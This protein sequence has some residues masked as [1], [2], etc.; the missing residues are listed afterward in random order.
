MNHRQLLEKLRL[1]NE[2]KL[3]DKILDKRLVSPVNCF[4]INGLRVEVYRNDILR[5]KSDAIVCGKL[6]PVNPLGVIC[7]KYW[8]AGLAWGYTG[9]CPKGIGEPID[10]EVIIQLEKPAENNVLV[11]YIGVVN[12][13][14][15]TI[16]EQLVKT[17]NVLCHEFDCHEI[18]VL[19]PTRGDPN[20]LQSAHASEIIE[21]IIEV[22][23]N[24]NLQSVFLVDE[25]NPKPFI[26]QLKSKGIECI[27]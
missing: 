17:I 5:L 6:T 25:W 23:S 18:S 8:G 1:C 13:L 7:R 22:S 24:K 3:S 21:G 2:D 14:E 12:P 16:K 9:D 26:D 10:D 19:A 15:R 11:K 27:A 4:Q 20:F